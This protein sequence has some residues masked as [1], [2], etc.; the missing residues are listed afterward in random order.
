MKKFIL[1]LLLGFVYMPSVFA[2]SIVPTISPASPTSGAP[3]GATFSDDGT[4]WAKIESNN[5]KDTLTVDGSIKATYAYIGQLM[6]VGNTVFALANDEDNFFYL[7]KD[8]IVIEKGTSISLISTYSS[9]TYIST[10]EG[11]YIYDAWVFRVKNVEWKVLMESLNAWS[12][13][14]AYTIAPNIVLTT[15]YNRNN[16]KPVSYINTIAMN[17]NVSSIGTYKNG[18]KTEVILQSTN[19]EGISEMSALDI[20]S[21]KIRKLPSYDGVTQN[22]AIYD[23]KW[24]IKEMQYV[25]TIGDVYAFVDINGKMTSD[26]RYDEVISLSS[27]GDKF[28]K[29]VIKDGKK[30]FHFDKKLYGPYDEIDTLNTS[31]GYGSTSNYTKVML[32]SIFARKD[33]KDFIIANGKELP[34]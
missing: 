9:A 5:N 18:K 11:W 15:L 25:V 31:F 17:W 10:L 27:H 12:S 1:F 6:Y 33:G 32:W 13:S 22:T 34:L 3:E 16:E 23:K 30:Y 26:T 4:H 14:S 24:N 7:L 2:L 20:A 28:F 19:S 8:G 21:G 29:S